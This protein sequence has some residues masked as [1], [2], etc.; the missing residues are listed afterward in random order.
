MKNKFL[1]EYFNFSKRERNG[2][3]ILLIILVGIILAKVIISQ[4]ENNSR[5]DF[6]EFENEID[7]FMTYQSY[8]IENCE[9]F[10]FDPNT[11]T[12]ED[13]IKMGLS[14]KSVNSIMNFREKGGKFY[15][16][17]D[18]QRVYNLTP[19]E[20]EHV[21]DYIVIAKK[22]Y[23]NNYSN[24]Y[25]K[26]E[27][28]ESSGELFN[29]DP[30]RAS[31]QDLER[32]GLKSWQADNVINYRE[33]GGFF[34][35]P[36]DFEKIYGLDEDLLQNLLPFV[37]IEAEYNP[38]T[39]KNNTI[40]LDINKA[41]DIELQKLSGIGPSYSKRI[42]DY[43]IKL[44]GY[45]DVSQ[46]YE[47][48][49]MTEELY[50]SIQDNLVVSNIEIEKINLNEADFKELVSHPY[51]DKENAINILNYR[52]FAGEITDFHDLVKQKAITQEFF[53][54]LLPYISIK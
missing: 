9:P 52:D 48:Y 30:N 14:P 34:A 39:N 12:P 16:P 5:V 15:K 13:F 53:N 38:N 23:A 24:S 45:V 47:V 50:S 2:F 29:F 19:E 8:D 18:F 27:E 7:V 51:I 35:K 33:K 20:H 31:K 42:V 32:L 10:F 41:T 43:R 6:E 3:V 25:S 54:K 46:L 28:V 22:T 21:K 40:I 49:G 26:N 4:V 17:E 37:E 11:A 44:G 36:E 1:R